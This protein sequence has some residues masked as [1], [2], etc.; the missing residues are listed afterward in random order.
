[1]KDKLNR[2]IENVQGNF[3]EISYHKAIYQCMD[4]AYAWVFALDIP[5]STIQHLY[6]Y[7][8][9]TKPRSITKKYFD[10]I[11]NTPE[12]I[13]QAGDL[14]VWKVAVAGH[15]GVATGE[16]DVNFF[17]VFEQNNPLGSN[18]QVHNRSYVNVIGFLRPKQKALPAP[19]SVIEND[20]IIPQIIDDNGN[21]MEVQAI[22][23]KLNDLKRDLKAAQD[24][25]EGRVKE[26]IEKTKAKE[27]KNC[28]E[29]VKVVVKS[30]E[31]G[32]D[33]YWQPKLETAKQDLKDLKVKYEVMVW[34]KV[35]NLPALILIGLGFKKMFRL[36]K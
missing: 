13:P 25:C 34:K 28:N 24:G 23:G 9:Y 5:K 29:R 36:E 11:P 6:A 31:L 30:A 19:E 27:L 33:E 22:R 1:M 7:E 21:A 3:V 35:K 12:F 16:G 26:A 8:V 15:I 20:T 4:L 17:K 14:A 18:A 10:L 32:R 2:F